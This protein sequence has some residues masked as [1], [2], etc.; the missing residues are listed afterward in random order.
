MLRHWLVRH[1]VHVGE[2]VAY[3]KTDTE[4]P[5]CQLEQVCREVIMKGWDINNTYVI[6]TATDKAYKSLSNMILES[7]K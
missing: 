5:G 4:K 7:L 3:I 2:P 1:G 6:E